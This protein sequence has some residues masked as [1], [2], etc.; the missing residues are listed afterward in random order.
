MKMILT[1]LRFIGK[2]F[3]VVMDEQIVAPIGFNVIFPG[4][5]SLAIGMGLEFPVR[6]THVHGILHLRE[7]ELKRFGI[8]NS[9][10]KIV[11]YFLILSV[12]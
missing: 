6:Q 3:S 11:P 9:G 5:L 7:M 12:L 4:M 8:V 1:G 10:M 2:Y